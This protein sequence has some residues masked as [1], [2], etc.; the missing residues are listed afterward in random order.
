MNHLAGEAESIIRRIQ[1]GDESLREQFIASSLPFIKRAAAQITH[2]HFVEQEDEFEIALE[3]FNDAINRF[4]PER[5][6]SFESFAHLVIRSRIYDWL[7]KQKYLQRA[8]SLSEQDFEDGLTLEEKLADPHSEDVQ[9]DL[10]FAEEMV[11]LELHL[12][13]FGFKLAQM[14]SH[15]P[16]HQDSRCLCIRI[17]RQLTADSVLYNQFMK[18]HHLPGREL[19]V[20]CQVPIKTIEKNRASIIFLTL[21]MKSSFESVQGYL[22]A[23]ERGC[24]H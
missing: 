16:K 18:S 5:A 4:D 19:S 20:R 10:E 7:R 11:E 17:A 21:L 13:E 1:A 22:T 3:S 14:A 12:Q 15:F 23:F 8:V 6:A 24:P 9:Q 2:S